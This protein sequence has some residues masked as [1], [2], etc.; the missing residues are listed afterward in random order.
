MIH[1]SS[2]W[3]KVSRRIQ[4]H[5]KIFLFLDY[6]G[7]LTPIV[8]RPEDARLLPATRDLIKKLQKHPRFDIAIISGRSL[9]DIKKM[10]AIKGIVYAGNHGLEIEMKSG[11]SLRP[12]GLSTKYLL[13]KIKLS[14]KKELKHIK[15][16]WI[17]DKGCTL[18][19]HFRLVEKKNIN[20]VKKAF[21]KTVLPY[22]VTRKIRAFSGKMVFEAR[23]GVEWDK[24]KTMLYLLAKKRK[25]LPIYIGDD[26]TDTDAFRAIRGKGISIFVG[27]PKR[28]ISA[29]YFLKDPRDVEGFIK[30]LYN[31]SLTKCKV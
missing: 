14:L 23:P 26:V 12:K 7:T 20:L 24:G 3:A 17:E 29:D 6:D 27:R 11:R 10:A 31:L 8:S 21:R 28:S 15:G 16:A 13:K 5:D 22:V 2:D 1:L 19:V 30:K 4:R 9:K 25:A 18:S